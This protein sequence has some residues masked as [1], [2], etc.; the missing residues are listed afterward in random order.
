MEK[1]EPISRRA[2]P[3]PYVPG[4]TV[5][6]SSSRLAYREAAGQG[7]H[8]L[9]QD[10]ATGAVESCPSS[11]HIKIT[12]LGQAKAVTCTFPQ[13]VT[14]RP[15]YRIEAGVPALQASCNAMQRAR[16]CSLWLAVT[17]AGCDILSS[18]V[19]MSWTYNDIY[20]HQAHSTPTV[21]TIVEA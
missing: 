14:A 1:S 8:H 19:S 20:R 9:K 16:K 18:R 3:S 2:R 5:S 7:S 11:R 21:C 10:R 15:R 12:Y 4:E 13:I 6:R 17:A